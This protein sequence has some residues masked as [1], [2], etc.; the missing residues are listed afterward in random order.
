MKTT[1]GWHCATALVDWFLQVM[2]QPG[3][4][5]GMWI[6]TPEEDCWG[7]CMCAVV[8]LDTILCPVHLIPV[9]GADLV[10]TNFHFVDCEHWIQFMN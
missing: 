1:Q 10:S 2:E 4:L 8:S 6:V 9:Y 3:I 7:Q 5:T